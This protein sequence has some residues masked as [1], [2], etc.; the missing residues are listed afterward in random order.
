ML[1]NPIIC[2]PKGTSLVCLHSLA[3]CRGLAHCTDISLCLSISILPACLQV[4]QFT[5]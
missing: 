3:A 1:V 4:L 5:F 2:L